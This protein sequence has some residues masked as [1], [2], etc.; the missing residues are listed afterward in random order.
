[1]GIATVAVYSEADRDA[2]RRAD[3]RGCASALPSSPTCARRPIIEACKAPARGGAPGYGFLS[4][5]ENFARAWPPGIV[6]IGPKHQSIAAMATRSSPSAPRRASARSPATPT[7]ADAGQAA[8]IAREVGYPVMPAGGGG[9]GL[10][11]AHRRRPEARDGFPARHQEAVA[12]ASATTASSSRSSSRSRATSRSRCW[13]TPTAT[14]STRGARV[15]DPAPAPE[16]DREAPSP[17]LDDTTRRR[18][19]SRRSLPRAVNYQSAG[20]VEF[21]VG[22][23]A[24]SFYFLEMNTRLQVEH[25]GHRDDH[26]PRSRRVDDPRRPARTLAFAQKDVAA[27]DGRSSAASTPRTPSAGSCRRRSP[28]RYRPPGEGR[29]PRGHRRLEGG[30]IRCT[31]TR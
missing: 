25:P 28:V 3:R 9:R 26:R 16:G 2:P 11:V 21:V 14:W 27:T 17:F 30:E 13:A 19:A 23:T 6:F 18:W 24:W 22:A 1:M 31:T 29:R 15:L 10:R 5:N 8:S 12:R 20:T 4:E 7:I